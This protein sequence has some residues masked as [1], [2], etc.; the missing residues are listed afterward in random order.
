[1]GG[2]PIEGWINEETGEVESGIRFWFTARWKKMQED[3]SGG[4]IYEKE[5]PEWTAKRD[6]A[7]AAGGLQAPAPVNTRCA[8]PITPRRS[9]RDGSI[10]D[11]CGCAA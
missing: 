10:V 3:F 11:S 2:S 9:K 1:V 4:S 8:G 6:A 5:L 7:K